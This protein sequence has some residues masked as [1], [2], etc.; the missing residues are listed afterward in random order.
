MSHIRAKVEVAFLKTGQP[1]SNVRLGSNNFRSTSDKFGAN[2]EE[3]KKRFAEQIGAFVE[4]RMH[5]DMLLR[6]EA[7]ERCKEE[8]NELTNSGGGELPMDKV[9]LEQ[10]KRALRKIDEEAD[11][12]RPPMTS[13]E[14]FQVLAF[15][16][17]DALKVLC[18]RDLESLR[19]LRQL[20]LEVRTIKRSIHIARTQFLQE[21]VNSPTTLRQDHQAM[22]M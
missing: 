17:L 9:N 8:L 20:T 7:L 11:P 14:I 12:K 4:Q 22:Q 19:A 16:D 21:V 6:R 18:D 15:P 3:R 5:D 2:R 13:E 10:L 1:V